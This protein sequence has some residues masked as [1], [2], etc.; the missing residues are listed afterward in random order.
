MTCSSTTCSCPLSA[1]PSSFRNLYCFSVNAFWTV[2]KATCTPK[3]NKIRS[4]CF[5]ES[6]KEKPAEKGSCQHVS[7]VGLPCI[8]S[9]VGWGNCQQNSCKSLI[10][11]K[12]TPNFSI[13]STTHAPCYPKTQ[14]NHRDSPFPNYASLLTNKTLKSRLGAHFSYICCILSTWPRLDAFVCRQWSVI[15]KWAIGTW[16]NFNRLSILQVG[17]LNIQKNRLRI[18]DSTCSSGL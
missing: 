13:D 2:R 3:T 6:E 11:P 8:P 4:I 9:P 14:A 10:F 1:S 18:I 5:W 16:S 7:P 17:E 15:R 12:Y